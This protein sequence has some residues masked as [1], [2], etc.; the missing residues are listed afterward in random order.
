M[1]IDLTYTDHNLI[2]PY[3]TKMC[4][5]NGSFTNILCNANLGDM[6]VQCTQRVVDVECM[7]ETMCEVWRKEMTNLHIRLRHKTLQD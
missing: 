7:F 4:N 5:I 2:M 6:T 3:S 1:K